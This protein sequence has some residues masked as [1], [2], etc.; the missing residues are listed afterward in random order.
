VFHIAGGQ[1][2]LFQGWTVGEM[3]EKDDRWTVAELQARAATLLEGRPPIAS[4][5][6]TIE[7][8]TQSFAASYSR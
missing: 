5:G 3:L 8:L 2:G 6:S 1:V 7:S 4:A